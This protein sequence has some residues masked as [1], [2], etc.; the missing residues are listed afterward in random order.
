MLY[1]LGDGGLAILFVNG[2]VWVGGTQRAQGVFNNTGLRNN[3]IIAQWQIAY[4]V[5][6]SSCNAVRLQRFNLYIITSVICKGLNRC[7]ISNGRGNNVIFDSEYII[8][9]SDKGG[10]IG[11]M[12]YL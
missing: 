5:F 10:P 11:L 9:L 3:Q 7:S 2:Y 8:V 4:S 1:L 12:V 6:S